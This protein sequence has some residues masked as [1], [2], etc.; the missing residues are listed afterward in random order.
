[1]DPTLDHLMIRGPQFREFIPHSSHQSK[2]KTK[3]DTNKKA[4]K[5]LAFPRN[6]LA[7]F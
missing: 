3:L 6:N 1:M 5:L 4:N 7:S 2:T